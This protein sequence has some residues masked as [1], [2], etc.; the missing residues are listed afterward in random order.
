MDH[1]NGKNGRR[2]TIRTT[3]YLL[4]SVSNQLAQWLSA[5]VWQQ[6][7]TTAVLYNNIILHRRRKSLLQNLHTG[8]HH[9]KQLDWFYSQLKEEIHTN[10]KMFETLNFVEMIQ[11][12]IK[13]EFTYIKI[14][15]CYY[16][17]N[18]YYKNWL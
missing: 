6:Q 10:S 1:S 4:I 8:L 5:L 2:W 13:I 15:Y 3:C 9:S 14:Q 7:S 12:Y 17:N 16:R 11:S 18:H